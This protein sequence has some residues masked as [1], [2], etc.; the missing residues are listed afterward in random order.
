MGD[1]RASTIEAVRI[2]ALR[3][4]EEDLRRGAIF[5]DLYSQ[6]PSRLDVY[7]A[8]VKDGRSNVIHRRIFVA[9]TDTAGHHYHPAA[10]HLPGSDTFNS[11]SSTS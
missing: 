6:E 3:K 8:A 5:F 9:Q 2:C 7:S 1:T 4:V 11:S 10:Y